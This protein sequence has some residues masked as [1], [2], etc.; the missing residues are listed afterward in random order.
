MRLLVQPLLYETMA[1]VVSSL[2]RNH[3]VGAFLDVFNNFF[4][5]NAED[6]CASFH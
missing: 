4:C 2:R 1:A 6:I 3:G 5:E